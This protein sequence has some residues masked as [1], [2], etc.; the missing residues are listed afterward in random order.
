MASDSPINM[1]IVDD[2]R[3]MRNILET[4]IHQDSSI[5]LVT[6]AANGQEAIDELKKNPAID[7]VSLDIQMPVMDGLQAIPL[8]LAIKPKL[9]IIIVSSLSSPNAKCTMDALALGAADYIEK[10]GD[11]LNVKQ[12]SKNLLLKIHTFATAESN[13]LVQHIDKTTDIIAL[14]KL[15]TSFHPEIIAIASSTGGPRALIEMLSGFSNNFLNN[16][17]F[18]ITQHIKKDFV[19]LLANN[20]NSIS[21][22]NC[23][24]AVDREE[25]RKGTIYLAPSDVHLEIHKIEGKLRIHL[26]DAPAENFCRPSADPMF[27]S[28]S[29]LSEKTLAVILTGIGSDGRLFK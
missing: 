10:P 26:S 22:L 16:K 28:L 19:E 4:I 9:K 12:F 17:I 20:I 14:R 3:V 21:K 2:S 11:K 24:E 27:N 23:K 7:I 25:V 13:H 1:I 8:L 5:K 15:P 6:T 18:F 29:K